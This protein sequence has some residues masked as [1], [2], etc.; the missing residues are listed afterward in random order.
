MAKYWSKIVILY[1][2]TQTEKFHAR[3]F[4]DVQTSNEKVVRSEIS[5]FTK[6]KNDDG[7]AGCTA[8][9]SR[10]GLDTG[11]LSTF[12]ESSRDRKSSQARHMRTGKRSCITGR[13]NSQKRIN[14]DKL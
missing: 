10:Q 11:S 5:E 7:I 9:D 6:M 13:E 4:D 1:S 14:S 12:V 2:T 3:I 8:D